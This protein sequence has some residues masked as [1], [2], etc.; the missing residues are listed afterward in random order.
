MRAKHL[1]IIAVVVLVALAGIGVTAALAAAGGNGN[2]GKS[3]AAHANHG[4]SESVATSDPSH[5]PSNPD[6]TYQ[7]KSGSTP[8]QD[9]IGADHGIDNNDK[10]GPGTD[11][12]NGCGNDP[13]R[14][15]D[16]N[17]WCGNKPKPPK[18]TVTPTATETP[19]VTPSTTTTPAEVLG[20]TFTHPQVLGRSLARTGVAVLTF[21]F[22]AV[23]LGAF[24]LA[25]RTI[26]KPRRR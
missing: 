15:D 3:E 19:E 4:P 7:G 8:D 16:N 2:G 23:A 12:N 20:E 21:A 24:G 14:E 10:V 25:L 5:D 1:L 13:D 22:V 18:P 9:R 17:G 26:A 11:G 6:G